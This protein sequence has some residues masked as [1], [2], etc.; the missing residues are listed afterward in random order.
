MQGCSCSKYCINESV[1]GKQ[2]LDFEIARLKNCGELMKAGIMFHKNSPYFAVCADVVLVNPPGT[3][4][5]HSHSITPN[6]LP[7]GDASVLKEYQSVITNFFIL[8][9]FAICSGVCST[10]FF[11]LPKFFLYS[12]NSLFNYRFDNSQ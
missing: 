7:S 6:P 3:L 4:P 1:S 9:F 10:F 8:Y 2:R 11:P 5:N 12:I